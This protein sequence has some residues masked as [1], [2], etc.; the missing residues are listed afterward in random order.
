MAVA[1][2]AGVGD[3]A[4]GH[5][6]GGEQG[7]GA[8]PDVVVRVPFGDVRPHRQDRLGSVRGLDLGLLVHA[9]H[10]RVLG[11]RKVQAQDVADLC[12][13]LRVGGE[14]EAL[15]AVRLEAEFAPVP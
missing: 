10:D 1:G 3:R 9:D 12:F 13:Q 6:Q 8:V 11:W 5:F 14:L 15:G 4:G 7:G 2:V